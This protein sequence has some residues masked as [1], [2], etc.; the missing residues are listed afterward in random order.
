MICGG[1]GVSYTPKYKERFCGDYK[2]AKIVIQKEFDRKKRSQN[3]I[4]LNLNLIF[5]NKKSYAARLNYT[6]TIFQKWIRDRDA[7][8]PCISC[9]RTKVSEWHAGHYFKAEVYSLLIF[10]E[11]NV[12]KQ[13]A[14][15]NTNLH[16]N[17]ANYRIGL[18]NKYGENAVK[19]LEKQAIKIQKTYSDDFLKSIRKKYK[20]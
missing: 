17:E 20:K 1:C 8:L 2:C 11:I 14:F 12:N 9:S 3:K 19:E 7:N 4:K 13:C 16:G 6:K 10:N 18:V 15:C 5:D